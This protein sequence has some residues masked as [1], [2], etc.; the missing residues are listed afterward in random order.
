VTANVHLDQI[1]GLLILYA[2]ESLRLQIGNG[3]VGVGLFVMI[4]STF[5]NSD[6]T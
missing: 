4:D 1:F 6:P 2:P 5:R 3:P